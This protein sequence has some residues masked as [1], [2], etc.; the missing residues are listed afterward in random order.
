MPRVRLLAASLSLVIL[1]LSS[2]A[3]AAPPDRIVGAVNSGNLVRL[4][5]GVHPKAQAKYDEGAVSASMPMTI[6]LLTVPSASQQKAMN[7]LLADQQN[8]RSAQFHKWLKPE[9]AAD[10]FGLSPNDLQKITGWLKSQGFTVVYT[11]RAKN[12]IVLRGSAAQVQN[13]FQTE[14]HHFNVDGE[15]HFANTA[16][17]A[18]PAGLSGIV[19]GVRGLNDFRL[20]PYARQIKPDYTITVQGSTSVFL[21]PGDISTIYDVGPLYSGGNDGTGQ[22]LAVM[23]QTDVYLA[24]LN[25][26][27]SG[28]SL[29]QITGCTTN[30]SNV[31]TDCS[32]ST[33]FA[34]VVFPG[35][36]DPGTPYS[37]DLAEAD[38]D[39]E[40]SHAV[41]PGATIVY[42]NSPQSG[43]FQSFYYAIDQAF[44]PVITLSYGLCELGESASGF[45][46][47]DEAELQLANSE[48][49][50]FM[51][52]SGD[53][54][55]AECDYQSNFATGGYA[56][57]YPASSPSVTGVGGTLIPWNELPPF[58]T[59]YFSATNNSNGGSALSYVPEFAWNDEQEWSIFCTSNPSAGVCTGNPG[60]NDWETAQENYVGIAAGG[61]GVSNCATVNGS[62]VCTSGFAQPSWQ[63]GLN[64][65]AVNPG[66][67]GE[68]NAG[69][70]TRYSPDV[71]LLASI[72][73]PG[74]VVCTAQSEVGGTGSASTCAS[75]INA[76]LTQCFTGGNCSVFGGTSVSAPIFAGMVSLLNDYLAGTATPG[77]GNINAKLYTL[78]ATPANGAFNSVTQGSIG[79]F[80]QPGSPANQ[81][82]ALRC[83]AGGFLGFDGS[84]FDPTTK[85]NLATGLGSV[86]LNNLASA[87]AASR[88]TSNLTIGA[89][90][91]SIIYGQPVTFTATLTPSDA[92]GTISFFNNGGGTPL[93]TVPVSGGTA[94]FQTT[95]LPVGTNNVSASYSGDG[96]NKP[97]STTT[98]AVVTVTAPDFTWATNGTTTQTVLA[99]QTTP[100]YNFTVT[101]ASG[102]N[103]FVGT[104]TFSCAFTPTDPTL[105]N[106]SCTFSPTSI[107]AG[108]NGVGG[109]PVTMSITTAGPNPNT[110]RPIQQRRRADN[111]MPWL[112]LSLPLAGV[113]IAGFAGRKLSKYSLPASLCLTV[114]MLGLLIA[115]GGGSSPISVSVNGA[116]SIFPNNTADAWPSQTTQFTAV[117]SNDKAAKGVTWA[118]SGS[119]ANGTIDANGL[120]TAP[121][122]VAGLPSS[123]T[124]T[125]TSV[126]DPSKSGQAS[127]TLLKATVPGTYTD[128]VT[129][130]ESVSG[131]Q[132]QHS[133]PVTITVQ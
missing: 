71:S 77:L 47:A 111:R 40:W 99:G 67:I 88:T 28:F 78:A 112:P 124:I 131:A 27:R 54:G 85:Y 43:I 38:I 44:A 30:G 72:Y 82:A 105:I 55:A 56:V 22:F 109:I 35:D 90:Q 64:S 94:S 83:P 114:G 29:P 8:P 129:A 76:M 66:G 49:I 1:I 26:F 74:Y 15:M 122:I 123:V 37:G 81:P 100:V 45:T 87:W 42:V 63:A 128:T 119:P 20:K 95:T 10:R 96:Y 60:L 13:T 61:G 79:A 73:W 106:S 132:V 116:A 24:D 118:V 102:Q 62:D 97:S 59:T 52:S 70:P 57:S 50:T 33:N 17:I 65:G 19:A 91:N 39:L 115:C 36:T 84:N 41:A 93:A 51:N 101:P 23:G 89:S 32:A 69:T 25:D 86:D 92:Q 133:A 98:P 11:A 4:Q 21:A 34:Y 5:N 108:T 68:I 16:P 53:S 121:E 104:V 6:T 14:I 107:A 75:G 3:V 2:F 103:V 120:Y 113:V 117:V 12:F 125:A 80:C 58:S 7:K 110:G 48:G 46:S 126:S 31:I 127:E 9:Q 130:T 18:I